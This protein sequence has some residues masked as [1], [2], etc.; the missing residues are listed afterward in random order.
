[1]ESIKESFSIQALRNEPYQ[2]SSEN[3]DLDPDIC[4][5]NQKRYP[6]LKPFT[7]SPKLKPTILRSSPKSCPKPTK[8]LIPDKE[9]FTL[10]INTLFSKTPKLNSNSRNK[11]I[12]KSNT[13]KLKNFTPEP[14]FF[15]QSQDSTKIIKYSNYLNSLMVRKLK[16]RQIN[17]LK[18]AENK[19]MASA[20]N[21]KALEMLFKNSSPYSDQRKTPLLRSR[22]PL[23]TAQTLEE[24]L[25]NTKVQEINKR[26]YKYKI[27]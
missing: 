20:S 17:K 22:L 14:L 27:H 16:L 15:K 6:T 19:T 4:S 8:K 1:M 12:S 25:K 7:L 3:L 2:D 21:Y 13:K 10:S 26:F 23:T 5:W 24:L 9:S 18:Q 11:S